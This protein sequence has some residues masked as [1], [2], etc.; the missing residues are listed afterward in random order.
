MFTDLTVAENL[1]HAANTRV[2][3]SKAFKAARVD[4]VLGKLGISHVRD[5]VIGDDRK[6]GLS[7]GERKRV[8]IGMELVA[9]PAV[10]CLDEPTTGLDSASAEV[11]VDL[12][13]SLADDGH[14][15]I[16]I[17]HQPRS[18]IFR[19]FDRVLTLAKGGIPAFM[20]TPANCRMFAEA[21]GGACPEG[22]NPADHLIDLVSGRVPGISSAT[23]VETCKNWSMNSNPQMK[24]KRKKNAEGKE[25][26][27]ADAAADAGAGGDILL[28]DPRQ[29][30][31]TL[32]SPCAQFGF[33]F[34]RAM[35]Q[36]MRDSG[37]T[38]L[39]SGLVIVMI[40]SL[41]AGFSPFI[42]RDLGSVYRPPIGESLRKFCPPFMGDSCG[43]VMNLGGLEQMLFFFPMALGCIGMIAASRAFN[44]GA[45]LVMRRE[46]EV[47]LSTVATC[48]AK[49]VADLVQ[50]IMLAL[51]AMGLWSLMGY[52][53][54]QWR[55]FV[56][57]LG[58]LWTTF[59]WG[60]LISQVCSRDV[61][62][63][64]CLVV[65]V[66][67]S[68]MNGVNPSLKDVNT[69]PV[70]NWLWACSFSRWVSEAIYF[71]FTEH[72]INSGIDVQHGADALGFFVS[73]EQFGVDLV[74]LYVHGVVLRVA[75]GIL[76]VRRV[77]QVKL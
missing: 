76:I 14:T 57:G 31:S 30:P 28:L 13:R 7:G 3:G 58:M 50:A 53:G 8:S 75:T 51:L 20:D 22:K 71:I 52:P 45:L 9:N 46:A 37:S 60:S 4:T 12:L 49:M 63:T 65:A 24:D 73:P 10:L 61:I 27:A 54:G 5:S 21:C 16:C 18:G 6:R 19:S 11:V 64:V 41:S 33:N 77:T 35:R 29:A 38:A 36:Q 68:A 56:L 67:F 32:A 42:Q 17:L 48:V 23:V 55:W 74:V 66:V 40:A 1:M 34:I 26:S 2:I 44:D 69:L 15:V 72:H 47:G 70:I 43:A 39:Y 59:G 25:T 62:M